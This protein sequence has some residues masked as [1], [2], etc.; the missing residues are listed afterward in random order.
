MLHPWVN[1]GA[2][3]FIGPNQH[4]ILYQ[5]I[6]PNKNKCDSGN[7]SDSFMYSCFIFFF[8]RCAFQNK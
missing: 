8:N 3:S 7:R 2:N 4:K 5:N 6:R 1:D